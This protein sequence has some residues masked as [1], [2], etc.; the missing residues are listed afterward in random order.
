MQDKIYLD[1]IPHNHAVDRYIMDVTGSKEKW[2]AVKHSLV[3]NKAK[4][5][6]L[7]YN[8]EARSADTLEAIQRFGFHGWTNKSIL[9]PN[10]SKYGG[11]SFVYNPKHLD[12]M[13]KNS[14]TL[15][16]S[17]NTIDQFY[18]YN[19]TNTPNLKNS[20]L[21]TYSFT[22]NTDLRNFGYIKDFLDSRSKRTLIRSRLGV[23]KAGNPNFK[24]NEYAW[25]RDEQICVNIRINIPI[26][27]EL[28]Y[29]FQLRDEEP[30]HLETG[31]AYTWDTTHPHRVYHFAETTKDRIH[32]VLG[33]SPWFDF[34]KENQC[35]IKN[36]F[37]GKH[38]IQMVMDGDIFSGL[39]LVNN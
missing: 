21:D 13:D 33:Y 22:E 16:T 29:L 32:F 35:W 34:D 14:S 18:D 26:V 12:E 5:K 11:L 31:Y 9:Q 27:T 2:L 28:D 10:I 24:F 15:G 4:L 39:E 19:T 20:Y 8:H 25:H 36:E 30:Y 37:W 3:K 7:D 38:P 17:R 6:I 1:E 23:I